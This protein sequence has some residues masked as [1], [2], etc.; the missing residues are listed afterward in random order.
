MLTVLKHTDLRKLYGPKRDELSDVWRR[1]YGVYFYLSFSADI[2]GMIL[3]SIMGCVMHVLHVVDR[4]DSQRDLVR[5]H[6]GNERLVS[7]RR[8]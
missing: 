5:K 8:V 7:S 4:S 6:E 2:N 3:S 1:L